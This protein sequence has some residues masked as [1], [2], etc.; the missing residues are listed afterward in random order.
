[1]TRHCGLAAFKF[2]NISKITIQFTGAAI[3]SV[4]RDGAQ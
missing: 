3:V 4:I 1:M 2:L